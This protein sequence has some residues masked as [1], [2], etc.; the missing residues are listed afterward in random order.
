VEDRDKRL[1]EAGAKLGECLGVL[2]AMIYE[3]V[4]KSEHATMDDVIV[5]VETFLDGPYQEREEGKSFRRLWE[6]VLAEGNSVIDKQLEALEHEQ[7]RRQEEFAK[8]RENIDVG[9][10]ITDFEWVMEAFGL[11]P[12]SDDGLFDGEFTASRKLY[13][14]QKA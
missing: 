5:F 10:S 11:G 3:D 1:Y 6:R 13:S 7:R 8:K 9:P 14:A 4:R 12:F 2:P